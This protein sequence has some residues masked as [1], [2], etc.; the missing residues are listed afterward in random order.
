MLSTNDGLQ[1]RLLTKA[2]SLDQDIGQRLAGM[3]DKLDKKLVPRLKEHIASDLLKSHPG[4]DAKAAAAPGTTGRDAHGSSDA[5]EAT[6]S[7]AAAASSQPSTSYAPSGDSDAESLSPHQGHDQSSRQ[8]SEQQRRSGHG[9]AQ[10]PKSTRNHAKESRP[11]SDVPGTSQ[12]C[13]AES[14]ASQGSQASHAND[15]S[16]GTSKNSFQRDPPHVEH[17]HEHASPSCMSSEQEEEE[18]GEQGWETCSDTDAPATEGTHWQQPWMRQQDWPDVFATELGAEAES[19]SSL[20]DIWVRF[21]IFSMSCYNSGAA[22]FR[23][24]A[25]WCWR[26]LASCTKMTLRCSKATAWFALALTYGEFA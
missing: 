4:R 20:Y 2:C 18:E 11:P 14:S 24:S 5:D 8:D 22:K 21:Q 17:H 9:V 19:R 1:G 25:A 23:A 12:Q 26:L 16:P 7:K 15:S 6:A 10:G 3:L 13:W